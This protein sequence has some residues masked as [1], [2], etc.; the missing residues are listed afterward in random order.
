MSKT[1]KYLVLVLS[2]CWAIGAFIISWYKVELLDALFIFSLV[3]YFILMIGEIALFTFSII[4]IVKDKSYISI[5]SLIVLIASV[6][7]IIVFPFRDVKF[8]YELNKFEKPRLEIVDMIKSGKLK[9]KDENGNVVLPNKY[10]KYSISG[11]VVEY[12]NDKEGQV[13][14]FWVFRGIQSGSTQLMYSTGGEDL[15]KENE[16]GHPII[17]IEKLKNNWYLVT[18]DY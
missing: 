12:Q 2:V 8:Q 9:S 6:I 17:K 1:E 4:G 16:T 13:I 10:K 15:I 7:F 18:T 3:P 11:E 5:I 14:A